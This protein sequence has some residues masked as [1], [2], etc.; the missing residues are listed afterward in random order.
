MIDGSIQ[1]QVTMHSD[2]SIQRELRQL[3]D[4]N[5]TRFL[6]TLSSV[7]GKVVI[8]GRPFLNFSSN[9]YLNL[10]NDPRLK[11]A[12]QEAVEVYGCG[13]TASRLMAGH[14]TIHG[15]LEARLAAWTGLEAALVFPSG[16][17]ANLGVITT[18]AG[19]DGAVLSDALNHASIVDG[20]R[21]AKAE[22][23]IYPHGDAARAADAL[24]RVDVSGRRVMVTDT[25][26]SMDGDV[27][28]VAAL[29]ALAQ[30]HGAY[31]AVDEAHALGVL[32]EGRGLCHEVGVRPDVMVGTLTKSLG[33]GGGFVAGSRDFID[34]LLN[35]AR[36]FIYSTGLAPACAGSALEA[37]RILE[38]EPGLGEELLRRSD[39]LRA[40]LRGHGVDIPEDRSQ[41]IPIPVGSNAAAMALSRALYDQGILVAGVRPPTVPEGTARLRISVTLAH[42]EADLMRLAGTLADALAN[43]GIPS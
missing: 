34:L 10:A 31:L 13:A 11:K 4:D 43:A 33:S 18:L 14:L 21:L 5:L 35:K 36:S 15:D 39:Y 38:M 24:R 12:A 1:V 42:D 6:R 8:E 23:H 7:G 28:P 22:T 30:E 17:Q 16:F 19:R 41:I 20:C 25:L 2:P 27:A 40:Q 9:D 26:F 32:G 29:S 3:D 37:L